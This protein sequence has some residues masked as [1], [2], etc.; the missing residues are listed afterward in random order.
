MSNCTNNNLVIDKSHA[1]PNVNQRIFSLV[2]HYTALDLKS[3]LKALTDPNTQVS[4]HYLIPEQSISGK[5]QIFQLVDEKERAWH[6]GASTWQKRINLNDSSI[7]IE[8]VNLGYSDKNGKRLWYPFTDYQIESVI[9]LAKIII[10]R[11]QIHPSCIIGHSDIAPGRKVDPGPLF[12]W[13]TLYEN[14]I[15]AWFEEEEELGY[16]HAHEI[17]ISSLQKNLQAYGYAIEITGTLDKQTRTILQ[18][19][20][21]HFRARDYSGNPDTETFAILENLLKKYFPKIK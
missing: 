15:G 19:F 2:L 3:S 1:S 11:Y 12:P 4:A 14:G 5:R 9:E 6:A 20:Q 21:M 17:D 10:A 7:G 18:A 8:I 13:K 16:N